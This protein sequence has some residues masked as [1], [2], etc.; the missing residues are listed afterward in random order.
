MLNLLPPLATA[1]WVASA[2]PERR[3]ALAALDDPRRAQRQL[4]DELLALHADAEYLRAHG[5]RAGEGWERAR[6][7]LPPRGYDEL[8]PWV[9]RIAAGEQGVLT[10]RGAAARVDRFEPS[11]GS[12]AAKKLIPSNPAGRAALARGVN[13]WIGSLYLEHPALMGGRAYWS[14]SP[15]IPAE[16]TAGGLPVGFQE[17]SAYLGGLS[18]WL[19]DQAQVA[20]GALSRLRDPAAWRRA[21]LH[22][23]LAAED[24]RLVSVWSPSF[25]SLLLDALVGGW[26]EALR[27]LHDG[28]VAEGLRL[29][30]APRRA[31]ALSAVRPDELRRIWPKLGLLSCWAD[32]EAAPGA[33]ALRA[34]LPGVVTQPKGLL[35]TEGLVSWPLGDQHVAAS[36]VCVIELLSGD[37]RLRALHE[38][39]EGDEGAVVITTAAGLWRYRLGDR[40]VVTGRVG[41][42]P[43]LRFLGREDKVVDLRGEKLSDAF[44]ASVLTR[45]CPEARFR[46]LAPEGDDPPRYTLFVEGDDAPAAADLDA[47]L[48]ENPHYGWCRRLG[49]L[50]PAEVARIGPGGPEAWVQEATARGQRLGDIKPAA[51]TASKGWRARLN[52]R[53]N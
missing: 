46:L 23:L 3:R 42:T 33:K 48:A 32:G 31:R 14:I 34:R 4:G 8:A 38:L 9:A 35:A 45:L 27:G 10:G 7:R 1:A 52:L 26:E 40:V 20:P 29:G 21:T 41:Q 28:V 53:Q 44:V 49:Q 16:R 25:L 30:A 6:E 11:S 2:L 39:G 51:L 17:D 18:A 12:A 47:A 5:V 24:L 43:T 36:R 15:A 19:V 37:G 50:G 22:C 13:A